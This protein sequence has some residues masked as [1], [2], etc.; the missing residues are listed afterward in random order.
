M[1]SKV[2]LAV[3]LAF[4]SI[5]AFSQF[6]GDAAPTPAPAGKAGKGSFTLKFGLAMPAANMGTAPS[7]GITPRYAEGYMGAKT[8][9]FVEAGMG[10]NLSKPESKVG[11]YYF[12]D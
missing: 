9:L 2:S 7:N 8:G 1:K 3:L 10:L 6:V 11:F 4:L 12:P 5:N